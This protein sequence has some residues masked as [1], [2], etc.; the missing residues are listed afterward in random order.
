MSAHT[1]VCELVAGVARSACGGHIGEGAVAVVPQQ[2]FALSHFPSAAQHQDVHAAVVVVIGLNHVQP[3]QLAVEP[4]CGG[5]VC[6]GAVA[7]VAEVV[8]R[9]AT[10]EI[11]RDDVEAAAAEIV[12]DDASRRRDDVQAGLRSHVAEAPDVLRGREGCRAESDT[13][14]EPCQD[15]GRASCRRD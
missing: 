11:G 3:A 1:A 14:A 5:P 13:R 9:P 4:C 7:V 15:I 10:V 6:E 2:R 12:D 8:H